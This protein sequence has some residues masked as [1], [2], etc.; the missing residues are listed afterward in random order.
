MS[1]FSC[2]SS[3][4]FSGVFV[5]MDS[6]KESLERVGIFRLEF[7]YNNRKRLRNRWI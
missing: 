4:D 3:L 2:G 5:L 7:K 1:R 6:A